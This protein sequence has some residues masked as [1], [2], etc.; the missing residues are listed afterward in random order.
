MA[1]EDIFLYEAD[2]DGGHPYKD[3]VI[4]EVMFEDRSG[5]SMDS[6]GEGM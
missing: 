3:G 5:G 6:D 1:I 4:I 2:F